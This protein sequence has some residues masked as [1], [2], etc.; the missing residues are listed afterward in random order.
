MSLAV[1]ATVLHDHGKKILI[2]KLHHKILKRKGGVQRPAQMPAQTQKIKA[3]L[4][5]IIVHAAI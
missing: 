3:S 4:P 5:A 1:P 2:A